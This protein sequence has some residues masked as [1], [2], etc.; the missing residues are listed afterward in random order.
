MDENLSKSAEGKDQYSFVTSILKLIGLTTIIAG[1]YGLG[2][3]KGMILT[4]NL[5]NLSGNYEIREIFNSAVLGYL[6]A[7]STLQLEKYWPVVINS[8]TENKALLFVSIAIG[9]IPPLFNKYQTQVEIYL[10]KVSVT[11]KNVWAKVFKSFIWSPLVIVSGAYGLLLAILLSFY[12]AI[13]FTSV[14]VLPILLGYVTG[15]DYVEKAME[16]PFCVPITEE[17][18]KK[19]KL[20]QCTQV[21]IKGKTITA[22]IFLETSDAYFMRRNNAFIYATKNGSNCIYSIH[23]NSS[24]AKDSDNFKFLDDEI[25]QF[26]DIETGE[27]WK[28]DGSVKNKD[29]S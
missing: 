8:I 6:H 12:M 1:L 2:Y 13:I 9:L 27:K 26:C 14:F 24:E 28:T 22:K 19:D 21:S 11:P 16:K 5:G 20:M 17:M 23:A 4:M 18:L 7:F 29:K 25:K 15:E 10:S 3:Q